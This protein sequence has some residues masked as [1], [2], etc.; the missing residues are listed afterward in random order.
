MQE[1][2]PVTQEHP[3]VT[4]A[5][6]VLKRAGRPML[7]SDIFREAEAAGLLPASARHTLRAR[8]SEHTRTETPLMAQVEGA[9]YALL[10]RRPPRAQGTVTVVWLK[11]RRAPASLVAT[12]ETAGPLTFRALFLRP[13][14]P[15]EV[16]WLARK[17]PGLRAAFRASLQRARGVQGRTCAY[18][19]EERRGS[20]LV[21]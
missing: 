8:L 18:M 4:A 13:L 1:R 21:G 16:E 9:G 10:R 19:H 7:P 2:R 11:R 12:V 6:E 15:V 20:R 14:A 5:V 17:T 3:C